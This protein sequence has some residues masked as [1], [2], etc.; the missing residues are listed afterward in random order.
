MWPSRRI[1]NIS[2]SLER[3]G[4]SIFRENDKG[5]C[6]SHRK[7]LC[8]SEPF[9]I[10]FIL[11]TADGDSVSSIFELRKLRIAT[12]PQGWEALTESQVTCPERSGRN[13]GDMWIRYYQLND[14]SQEYCQH[15]RSFC[16]QMFQSLSN[17][18]RKP[19]WN[20]LSESETAH[21]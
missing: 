5:K 7:D 10:G 8:T 9:S 13:S 15:Y 4:T 19:D 16:L 21:W 2:L 17:F 18:V 20:L 6:E 1:I 11:W 12:Q 14:R 3:G